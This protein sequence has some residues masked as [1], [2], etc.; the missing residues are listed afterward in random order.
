M[1]LKPEYVASLPDEVL[2]EKIKEAQ[3]MIEEHRDD[4][5][6]ADDYREDLRQLLF[7]SEKR[8]KRDD[9]N[10]EERLKKIE[11]R[12]DALEQRQNPENYNK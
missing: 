5:E 8:E 3:D 9:G 1:A 7:E 6:I 11:A 10:I 2:L 12:L 4:R